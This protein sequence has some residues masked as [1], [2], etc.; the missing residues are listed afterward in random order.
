VTSEAR[1]T[2]AVVERPPG[3]TG[4]VPLPD[5]WVVERTNAWTGKYLRNRKDYERTLASAEAMIRVS[6]I[7]LMVHR[8]TP[9]PTAPRAEFRDPRRPLKKAA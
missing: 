1:Y 4:L 8:L 6:M 3:V 7:Y 9:D 2:I 5:W